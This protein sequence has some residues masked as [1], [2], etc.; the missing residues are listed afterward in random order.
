MS[1]WN[2]LVKFLQKEKKKDFIYKYLKSTFDALNTADVVKQEE[3]LQ[4]DYYLTKKG[5]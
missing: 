5:Y 1:L 4:A 2:R 3:L